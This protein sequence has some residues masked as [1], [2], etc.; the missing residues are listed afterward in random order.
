MIGLDR[1]QQAARHG[2]GLRTGGHG[3]AILTSLPPL[4]TWS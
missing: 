2:F 4:A 3:D 1:K